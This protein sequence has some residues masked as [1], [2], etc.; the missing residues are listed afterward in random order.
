MDNE[1]VDVYNAQAK[2]YADLVSQDKPDRDLKAFMT[3]VSAGGNLLD[4]GC[5]PG[6]SASAMMAA[7]FNVTATDASS[8][9]VKMA[10]EQFGVPAKQSLFSDINEKDVYDGVWANFSL[11]HAPRV[12]FPHHLDAIY[13]ALRTKGILHL[14]LK[15][16]Q[17][18]MRDKIGRLYSYYSEAELMEHLNNSGLTLISQ[19]QGSAKGLAGA[20][21]PFIILL[22]QKNA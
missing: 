16:G 11:L 12:D 14:G 18:E 13:S 19:R 3:A 1:T 9:M 21:E 22:A 7:G 5:G 2:K 6:N 4:L 15:L 10:K 17:G 8:E 20:T